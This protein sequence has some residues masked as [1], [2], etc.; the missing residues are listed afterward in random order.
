[1]AEVW[2]GSNPDTPPDVDWKRGTVSALLGWWWGLW[3]IQSLFASAG[4]YSFG[5]FG[6]A[7]AFVWDAIPTT[8]TLQI[9]LFSSALAIPAGV[10]AIQVVLRI[11]RRQEIKR[12]RIL[13]S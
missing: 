12:S 8:G 9:D 10:L 3:I 4:G 1:M 11:T 13:A 7:G 5:S 2:R 6:F